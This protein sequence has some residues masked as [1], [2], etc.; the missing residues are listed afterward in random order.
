MVRG[1]SLV[2]VVFALGLCS[3]VLVA[4]LG[5]VL[6]GLRQDRDSREALA[7]MTAANR[8]IESYRAVAST[9][10]ALPNFPLPSDLA[11]R[12]ANDASSPLYVDDQGV[13]TGVAAAAAFGVLYRVLPS[14]AST[15]PSSSQ[16]YL[17]VYWPA[18]ASVAMAR[19][20]YE[21]VTTISL[22]ATSAN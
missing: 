17:Y 7:A 10:N 4:L 11:T 14:S 13:K 8:I 6:A 3:F 12:S 22:A 1:F 20:H 16:V 19:G 21:V 9:K 18:A 5:L 15:P 2:E